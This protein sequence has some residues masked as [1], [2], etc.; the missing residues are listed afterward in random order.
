VRLR[1]LLRRRRPPR[2]RRFL[3]ILNRPQVGLFATLIQVLGELH[4]CR[5]QD[6]EPVVF[7]GSNWPYWSPDGHRGARNGWEYY[8]EPVSRWSLADVLGVDARELERRHIFDFDP[9]RIVANQNPAH[10][11]AP[12]RRPPI[13]V[14]SHVTLVNRWP[15]FDAGVRS[16]HEDRRPVFRALIDAYV[17]PRPEILARVEAFAARHLAG[18]PVV[19]VHARDAEHLDEIVGWHLMAWAPP[20]LYLRV[21]DDWLDR[22]PDGAV[23]AATDTTRLLDAFRRR[24]GDRCVAWP[25][26]R[27]SGGGA[28]HKEFGGP[29]VGEEMLIEGLLLARTGHLVHGIS[30]VALAVLCLAPALSHVDVYERYGAQLARALRRQLHRSARVA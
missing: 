14:P 17:R 20:R 16:V 21:V 25:A 7:F 4:H 18:R 19:G 2:D 3:G 29:L 5:E 9:D 26:R 13:P 23:L 28:P 12:P 15:A 1:D 11:Y 6:L 22:N 24:Y 10:V 27:S 8:F 30:N